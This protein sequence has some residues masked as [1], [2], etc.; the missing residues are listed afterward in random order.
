[1][2]PMPRINEFIELISN[3]MESYTTTLFL[4]DDS[5]GGELTLYYFY[6]LSKNIKKD[7]KVQSGE[8]IIGWVFREQKSVLASYFDKRNEKWISKE[9][10]TIS[11][12][13]NLFFKEYLNKK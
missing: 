7:C 5:D 9:K 10:K 11:L 13:S 6:S 1:M 12:L 3:I 4:A 2:T 8:G